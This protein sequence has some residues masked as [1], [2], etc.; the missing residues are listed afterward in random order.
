MIFKIARYTV[1]AEEADMVVA[2][3][4]RFMHAVAEN[5]PET[6][7]ES[8]RISG[9]MTFVHLMHFRDYAAEERHRNARIVLRRRIL[10]TWKPLQGNTCIV[11]LQGAMRGKPPTHPKPL[12]SI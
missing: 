2:A 1:K 9:T 4:N 5:E 7:Y 10:K 8:Y 11:Q 12:P 3:I 6:R